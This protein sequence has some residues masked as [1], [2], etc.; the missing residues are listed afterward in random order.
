MRKRSSLIACLTGFM[1]FS[2]TAAGLAAD[3]SADMINKAGGRTFKGKIFVSKDKTRME[4]PE[5]ISITRMDKKV[6]WILMPKEKMYMEQSFN[7]A[8]AP[9]TSEKVTGEVER[10]KIGQEVIDGKNTDKYE[11]VYLQNK[12]KTSMYQWIAQSIAMPVKMAAVDGSWSIEYKNIKTG[13]QPDSIFEIPQGYQSFSM[14]KPTMK[15]LFKGL[16]R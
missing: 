8:Q 9:A 7:P 2:L 14:G 6:V 15:D 4:S 13:K 16:S 5:S 10:K 11:V 1:L 12:K 3:F